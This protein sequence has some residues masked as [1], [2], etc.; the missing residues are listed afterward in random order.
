[1]GRQAPTRTGGVNGATVTLAA[2]GT[3]TIAAD[4]AGDIDWA[5]APQVTQ[6]FAVA[7]PAGAPQFTSASAA[8]FVVKAP[9]AFTVTATGT[10]APTLT[11]TGAL[12]SGVTFTAATGALAGTPAGGTVGTYTLTFTAKNGV[13]PDA[14]QTFTL[15][16]IKADQ[17]IAFGPLPDLTFG[18]PS[19]TLAAT[20]TSALTVAFA[21][22]TPSVCTVSTRTVKLVAAGTCTIAAGQAGNA[23]YNP[24]PQVTQSFAVLIAATTVTTITA[25]KEPSV[26]GQPYAVTVNVTSPSGVP[27]G[28]VTVDDGRGGTCTDLTLSSTGVAACTLTSTSAG[29]LTLTAAYSGSTGHAPSTGTTPHVVNPAV[30][31]AVVTSSADPA[32]PGT[33]VTLSAKVTAVAPG[34][35]VPTGTVE[36]VSGASV[37]GTGSLDAAGVATWSSAAL[38]IGA[39][40]V[41][42][43][44]TGDANFASSAS[45]TFTQDVVPFPVL[46]FSA[47]TVAVD[48]IAGAVTLTVVHSGS[49]LGPVSVAYASADG[50]ATAPGD[51]GAVGGVLNWAAGDGANQTI[52]VPI[53][54][55]AVPEAA[56]KFTVTLSAPTGATLGTR[57]TVTV[58]IRAN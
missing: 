23:N 34:K 32:L 49:A 39:T 36:F 10:P 1:M 13:A 6:S 43:N 52:V 2:T 29:T 45:A 37:L 18:S 14:V 41:V 33:P 27:K 48:E 35:G 30:T 9:N 50:T 46:Q 28:S 4:Q 54:A 58:T 55:D 12:P 56:K 15:T 17:T 5:P 42:A 20:A 11:R 47:S 16:V 31:K 8:T 22:L 25:S 40:P 19:F 38:P 26:T 21:S 57:A 44:Y 51:Y 7:A 53:V 3:C 24:A